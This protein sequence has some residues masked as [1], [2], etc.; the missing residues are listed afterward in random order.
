MAIRSGPKNRGRLG[1]E[2]LIRGLVS[3]AYFENFL[4]RP[5]LQF[6]VGGVIISVNSVLVVVTGIVAAD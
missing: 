4:V 1:I 2:L 3:L 6:A 5:G